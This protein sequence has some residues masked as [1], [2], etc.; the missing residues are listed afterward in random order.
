ML[1]TF[2][3]CVHSGRYQTR[4]QFNYHYSSI[5]ELW[6]NFKEY[7]SIC[8]KDYSL[9][10]D[11]LNVYANSIYTYVVRIQP[12]EHQIFLIKLA[13]NCTAFTSQYN[14]TPYCPGVDGLFAWHTQSATVVGNLCMCCEYNTLHTMNKIS[15]HS[16]STQGEIPTGILI[17]TLRRENQA[18]QWNQIT[19][20]RSQPFECHPLMEKP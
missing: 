7:I 4:S 5:H 6:L 11:A 3:G 8:S 18:A 13:Y 10:Q 17:E 1:H 14:S 15:K 20:V 16:C 12:Y 2:Y 9:K 19:W